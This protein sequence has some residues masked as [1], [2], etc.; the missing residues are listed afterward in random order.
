MTVFLQM[1]LTDRVRKA[2]ELDKTRLRWEISRVKAPSDT[3]Q[4]WAFNSVEAYYTRLAPIHE[5]LLACVEAAETLVNAQPE[6]ARRLDEALRELR[7]A[8][9]GK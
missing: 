9:E 3:K 1:T 5:K 7:E 2:L 6:K 4:D 8:V